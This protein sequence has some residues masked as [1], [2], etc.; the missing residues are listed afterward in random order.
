MMLS[1]DLKL[2]HLLTKGWTPLAAHLIVLN[3]IFNDAVDIGEFDL[4]GIEMSF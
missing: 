4:F 2:K 1:G 3:C